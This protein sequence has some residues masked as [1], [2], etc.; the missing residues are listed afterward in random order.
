MPNGGGLLGW[1]GWRTRVARF[2]GGWVAR[3][4]SERVGMWTHNRRECVSVQ[5]VK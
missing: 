2:V 5:E 4:P 1:P 3:S